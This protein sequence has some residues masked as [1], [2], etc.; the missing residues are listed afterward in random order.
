MCTS[1]L[2]QPDCAVKERTSIGQTATQLPKPMH[3]ALVHHRLREA[4]PIL[5]GTAA[6]AGI[7]TLRAEP[8]SEP[9]QPKTR[10]PGTEQLH[11]L[12]AAP[13]STYSWCYGNCSLHRLGSPAAGTHVAVR[14]G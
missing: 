10:K 13:V 1:R 14:N 6:L 12:L 8:D 9:A 11:H 5:A 3:E 2:R 4:G 7:D